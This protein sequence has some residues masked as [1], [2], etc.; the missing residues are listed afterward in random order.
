MNQTI[1]RKMLRDYARKT[2]RTIRTQED[3]MQVG[4]ELKKIY[5]EVSAKF[6]ITIL[7]LNYIAREE[8]YKTLDEVENK[9]YYR[10]SLKRFTKKAFAEWGFYDT[11]VR[12]SMNEAERYPYFIDYCNTSYAGIE[13]ELDFLTAVM[14]GVLRSKTDAKEPDVMAHYMTAMLMLDKAVSLFDDFFKICKEQYGVD[15]SEDFMYARI[16]RVR[17]AWKMA[18]RYFSV[19]DGFNFGK[20]PECR[21]ALNAVDVKLG[22]EDFIN[23]SGYK[24]AYLDP[25]HNA[26]IIATMEKT[27]K[28]ELKEHLSEKYKVS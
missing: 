14:R 4:G 19:P 6:C 27:D 16:A 8:M 21:N 22:S 5:N 15:F 3:V 9:P 11:V 28:E 10:H 18:C 23:E 26:D 24:A 20:Y 12:R 25:T 7:C 17:D 1:V 2:H 13:K